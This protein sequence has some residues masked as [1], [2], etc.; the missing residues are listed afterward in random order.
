MGLIFIIEIC[1]LVIIFIIEDLY[2]ASL[3]DPDKNGLWNYNYYVC[4]I[5]IQRK[6]HDAGR[7]SY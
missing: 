1:N 3:L 5:Y 4:I 6:S 7:D 2:T